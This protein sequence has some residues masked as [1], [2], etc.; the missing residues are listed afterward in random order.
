VIEKSGMKERHI[1]VTNALEDFDKR[2]EYI[3]IFPKM[4]IDDIPLRLV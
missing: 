2:S 4:Y 1:L 3:K